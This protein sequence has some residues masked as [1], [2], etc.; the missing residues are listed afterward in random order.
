MT[1]LL[2]TNLRRLTLWVKCLGAYC[3]KGSV[4]LEI[5]TWVI[6]IGAGEGVTQWA[7]DGLVWK[8]ESSW[9]VEVCYV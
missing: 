2:P 8:P 3:P 7:V 4:L 9:G 5:G 1:L 6:R